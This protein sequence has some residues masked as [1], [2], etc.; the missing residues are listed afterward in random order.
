MG[1]APPEPLVLTDVSY[2]DAEFVVDVDAAASA[3]TLFDDL[4][5][6]RAAG[7]RV[8]GVLA[9]AGE[10]ASLGNATSASEDSEREHDDQTDDDEWGYDDRAGDDS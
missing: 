4:Q 9:T 7:A 3:R 8:A 1:P 10:E 6:E 2:S 5:A